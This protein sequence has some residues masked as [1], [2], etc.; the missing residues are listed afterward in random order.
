MCLRF[1]FLLV[2][3]LGGWPRLRRREESW[4]DAEILLLRHQLAVLRR[5][6]AARP[7]PFPG[8]PGADRGAARRDPARPA[9]SLRMIV[10]LDTVLRWH[11]DIIRRR[12][13]LSPAANGPAGRRRTV[14]GLGL[15]LARE[16]TG[17]G[18]RRIHGELASLGIRLALST[19]WEALKKAG[20]GPA[21]AWGQFL[22]SQAEAI[23]A[24]GIFTVG[25]PDG[26]NAY[27]LA[28]IEHAS[29][30]I[31]ILGITP[32]PTGAWVTQQARNLLMDP[33]GQAQT[34]KFPVRDRDTKFTAAFDEAFHAAHIRTLNSPVQA[35]RAN[36]IMGR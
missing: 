25:L 18:Y 28:V 33:D 1:V 23:L 2:T 15:R 20:P 17:W 14:R 10:T 8:G 27:V 22:R 34:I 24:A 19:V 4:K 35:P 29:R 31:R 7:K 36:A 5:Q 3:R 9:A 32:H 30:R 16:N 12:R 13:R 21:T 11:P 26:T 6:P